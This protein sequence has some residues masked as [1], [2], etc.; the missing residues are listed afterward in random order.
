VCI[1]RE[2]R[3]IAWINA[4]I[5]EPIDLTDVLGLGGWLEIG[6]TADDIVMSRAGSG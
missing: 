2:C 3:P 5:D 4:G 6:S 1:R